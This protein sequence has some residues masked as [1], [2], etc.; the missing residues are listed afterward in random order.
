MK[1]RKELKVAGGGNGE[2]VNRT[3]ALSESILRAVFS[4]SHAHTHTFSVR[5][6]QLALQ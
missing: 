5:K 4:L 2:E 3:E 6:T 1:V